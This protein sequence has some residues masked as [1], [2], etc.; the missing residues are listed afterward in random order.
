MNAYHLD[1]FS[2]LTILS[3]YFRLLLSLFYIPLLLQ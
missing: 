2:Y 3:E 1:T